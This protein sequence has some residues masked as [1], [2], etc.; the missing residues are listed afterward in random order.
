MEDL[1]LMIYKTHSGEWMTPTQVQAIA[2]AIKGAE[3]LPGTVQKNINRLA[4]NCKLVR[5]KTG[6]AWMTFNG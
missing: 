5:S 3:V 2:C 1:I 4:R 6:N